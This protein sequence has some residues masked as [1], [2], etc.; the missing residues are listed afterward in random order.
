MR[1]AETGLSSS[2]FFLRINFEIEKI[3]NR[4]QFG[5]VNHLSGRLWTYGNPAYCIGFK[6]CH[7]VV[8]GRNGNPNPWVA[9]A[10]HAR[11]FE[12]DRYARRKDSFFLYTARTEM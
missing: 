6:S 5:F 11:L 10:L 3:N 9:L 2:A 4:N 7:Y 8:Q 1:A 12:G